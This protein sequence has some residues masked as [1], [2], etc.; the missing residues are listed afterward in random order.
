L[1]AMAADVGRL[2]FH[3]NPNRYPRLRFAVQKI[4]R[5]ME[6]TTNDIS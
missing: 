5:E 4:G 6:R 2:S 1:V 3:E